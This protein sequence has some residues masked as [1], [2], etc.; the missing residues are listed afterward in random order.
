LIS[1]RYHLVTIVAVF[2]ALGLGI[3]AGTTVLNQ[4]LVANLKQRTSA[5]ERDVSALQA[6][7]QQIRGD[8]G[9]L[10]AFI[11]QA[12]PFLI[13]GKLAG[14]RVVLLTQDGS[15]P[16]AMAE[17]KSSLTDA[18]A[19]VTTLDL[20]GRMALT[21]AA[22]RKDLA[23]LLGLPDTAAIDTLQGTA[24][25]TLADRLAEGPPPTDLP[26]PPTGTRDVLEG[27]LS[28]GF[29]KATSI[30]PAD[31][32]QIGGLDQ[33]MVVVAGGNSA[34]AVPLESFMIPLVTQLE[35]HTGVAVAAGESTATTTFPFV[36]LLRGDGQLSADPMVTVDDLDPDHAGGVALVLGLQDLVLTG[37]G[38]NYGL[39]DGSDSILPKA[40]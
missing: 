31:V 29:L 16:A 40:A 2:L 11:H 37:T 6:Q 38:G 9:D 1:F 30:S 5:A 27:L 22:S 4:R 26:Q 17:A 19:K 8:V 12:R 3:L 10:Q 33:A 39:K 21:D 15:D 23:G 32:P 14:T 7:L 28:K 34:P 13:D 24:A 35:Q 25:R 18:G 36:S 20:T